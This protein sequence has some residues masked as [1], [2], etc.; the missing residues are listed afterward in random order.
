M[1]NVRARNCKTTKVRISGANAVAANGNL[2]LLNILGM[3]YVYA[4]PPAVEVL[5]F[6]ES[7]TVPAAVQGESADTP[8]LGLLGALVAVG[9]AVV[10]LRRR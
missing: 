8:G 9:L 3:E 4:T 10:A 7:G 5:D 2:V 1:A 6:T